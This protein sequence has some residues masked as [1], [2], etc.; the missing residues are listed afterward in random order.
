[1][2]T[3][4]LQ[5]QPTVLPKAPSDQGRC[6]TWTQADQLQGCWHDLHQHAERRARRPSLH[7]PDICHAAHAMTESSVRNDSE[8]A[9]AVWSS[10]RL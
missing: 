9:A 2:Q 5:P 10:R 6:Q 3:A 1:M 8:G 7:S 4:R